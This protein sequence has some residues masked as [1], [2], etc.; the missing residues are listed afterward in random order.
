M[1]RYGR[2]TKKLAAER[3][4][5]SR[6]E[7]AVGK[8]FALVEQREN[9]LETA[10]ANIEKAKAADARST[11]EGLKKDSTPRA[12]A[13]RLA[14]ALDE[15]TASEQRLEVAH[16]ALADVKDDREDQHLRVAN[17]ENGILVYTKHILVAPLQ[18][19]YEETAELKKRVAVNQHILELLLATEHRNELPQYGDKHFFA[20]M[21]AQDARD[22]VYADLRLKV[23]KLRF[24]GAASNDV[25]AAINEADAKW[26][27]VL[28]ALRAVTLTWCC[29]ERD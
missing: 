7:A 24:A 4:R 19:L 29:R 21:K 16:G 8:A 23:D 20:E 27:A 28:A 2:R 10:R 25:V 22:A 9:E 1:R 3:A 11:A 18:K 17:A 26:R 15:V 6:L 13:S 5:L 14:A 12:S